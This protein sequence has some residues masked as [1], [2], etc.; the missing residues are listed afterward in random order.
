MLTIHDDP[1]FYNR[2]TN[3]SDVEIM[4]FLDE[5]LTEFKK[6]ISSEN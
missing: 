5:K 2:C 1:N 4:Q 6:I 3:R